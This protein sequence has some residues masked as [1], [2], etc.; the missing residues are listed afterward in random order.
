MILAVILGIAAMTQAA[1]SSPPTGDDIVVV[2]QRLM[3]LKIVMKR[4]RR[5]KIKTCVIRPTSGDPV[6]D[7]GI[8]D[9]YLTCVQ[10]VETSAALDTCM[11]PTLTDLVKNWGE[12]RRTSTQPVH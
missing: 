3:N 11:R 2:G 9:T 12:H 10:T 4:D 7:S 8:C 6:F 1:P 5:T